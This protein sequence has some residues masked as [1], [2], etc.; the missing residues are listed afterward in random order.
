ML[1]WWLAFA[2]FLTFLLLP[3]PDRTPFS[4]L[5]MATQTQALFLLALVVGTFCAFFPPRRRVRVGWLLVLVAASALKLVLAPMVQETGWK[6][7]YW[8]VKTW[9]V[10]ETRLTP[11]LFYE[12]GVL[13][14]SRIDRQID[15][16]RASFGLHFV[17]NA[18]PEA[19]DPTK[20]SRDIQYPLR[21]QWLGY[22][23]PG[24]ARTLS[25]TAA[26]FVA[27]DVDG[28]RVF[29][30][31]DPEAGAVPLPQLASGTH[32]IRVTYLKPA[33]VEAQ[34]AV[35]YLDTQVLPADRFAALPRSRV[36][37]GAILLTG[38]LA[39]LALAGAFRS[40][41][42]PV[43]RLFLVEVWEQPSRM[44]AI[45]L[46]MLFLMLGLGQNVLLRHVT[47]P[48]LL[49][50]D[51][52]T[53]ESQSRQILH[54]GLL[55]V[56]DNGR[57]APY[58]HYPLYPYAL[59][60][61]HALF[62]EDF[63]TVV[64]FNYLCLAGVFL[65]FR[66]ILRNRIAEG[67]H[68]AVLALFAL[69]LWRYW[70]PYTA[71]AY[72]DNLYLPIVFGTIAAFIEAMERPALRRFALVGLLTALG[73]ATRPSFLIFVPFA[74]LA[75][76]LQKRIGTLL[77]RL[78]A[79]I[80]F[81]FGFGA[82]VSPFTWRNWLV[83][84]RFVLLV[85]SFVMLPMFIYAPEEAAPPLHDQQGR[86]LG[87]ITSVQKFAEIF[88][89][90]PVKSAWVEIR[91]IGFTFGLTFLGPEAGQFPAIFFVF[92]IAFA[93]A[94]KTKRIP[95]SVQTVILA[96]SASHVAAC[97]IATPWTY[98]YKTIVPMH[99]AFILGI[100]FLLPKWGTVRVLDMLERPREEP[101]ARPRVSVVLP[102]YNEKDSIRR[103][104]QDFFA[105]GAADEV[106]VINNNAAP[107]TSEEVAGTGAIE[108]F[109]SEQ[110][111]GAACQRGLREA[112]GDY[113]VLSEP[114]GTFDAQDIHKLLAY[115]HDFDVVFGSRTSQQFVRRGANMGFFLRFGN[116]AVA[117]YLQFLFNGPT[118]TD[119]GCTMRLVKRGVA[120]ELAGQYR[121]KGSHF[122]PEMMALTLRQ[123][124][125]RTVQIPVNYRPR[126]GQS[127][128]TGDP[129]TAFWLGLQMIWLI[130]RHAIAATAEEGRQPPEP[131]HTAHADP[132][133][134]TNL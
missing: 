87:A 59:A 43:S 46:V 58:F 114:D 133:F 126:V 109:E 47:M 100:A 28:V 20:L 14:D 80:A 30:A 131:K 117:K 34:V 64:M 112:T 35:L 105:T 62:G 78:G 91:K 9:R 127:S 61:A 6:S 8:W 82:G 63:G 97:L 79:I 73:A 123:H 21:V 115:A 53:Y 7:T 118:L 12:Q 77:R 57:G 49:G 18:H 119:V 75:I 41:Y 120:Q 121:I 54:H 66:R 94:L 71:T 101:V 38:L 37:K 122:G 69:L 1:S 32:A 124:H 102:T 106:I 29:S 56:D 92:P 70:T 60:G 52:L 11:Q 10:A 130:T 50:D 132:S 31:T 4:G 84:G 90:H 129:G 98:G 93:F 88:A 111:Y 19:Y 23:R 89:E 44:A 85:S 42:G 48:L 27:I 68:I 67:A 95:W 103:V 36:A 104:I 99:F 116:W 72:S 40:A 74:L 108:I 39:M 5:P 16:N 113:I 22:V 45:G 24:A 81:V 128:V 125:Y 25:V 134:R 110:G 13:R 2:L 107:G 3:G 51:F 33:R 96:F 86:P 17:N 55:M 65:V 26:G 83:S 76:V 15:Y